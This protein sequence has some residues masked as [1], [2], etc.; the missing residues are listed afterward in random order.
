MVVGAGSETFCPSVPDVLPK[1]TRLSEISF[2]VQ[3]ITAVPFGSGT[4]EGHVTT[5]SGQPELV[6]GHVGDPEVTV[7]TDYATSRALLVEQDPAAAMQAFMGGKIRVPTVGGPVMLNVPAGSNAGASLR[8][9]GRGLLDR[10][11]GQRGD[12][13]VK[14]R[15][16]LPDA[17]DEKLKAFL[18]GWE[19]GRAQDPRKSMEQFT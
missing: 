5:A 4:F 18:E 10:R 3:V 1:S 17:P 19:T 16:V 8:L 12:Q 9:K 13:Y 2:V 11:S 15:I 7:T 14:L 6:A